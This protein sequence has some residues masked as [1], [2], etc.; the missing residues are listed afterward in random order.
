MPLARVSGTLEVLVRRYTPDFD[1]K[2][3]EE[4]LRLGGYPRFLPALRNAPDVG[5]VVL[6]GGQPYTIRYARET[7]EGG[8]RTIVVVTDRPVFFLGAGAGQ[9]KPRAG[10]EVAVLRI[11]VD[12]KGAGS[13][14]MAGGCAGAP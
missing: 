9:A 1:R 2:T 8:G 4:A 12:A 3:M 14:T 11:Q 13:G 7:V 5:Q 10:Y 6:G